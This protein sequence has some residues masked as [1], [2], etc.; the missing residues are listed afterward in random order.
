NA[1]EMSRL[2][3][4]TVPSMEVDRPE[5]LMIGMD[6]RTLFMSN[7]VLLEKPFGARKIT[8][9]NPVWIHSKVS[10]KPFY[11]ILHRIDVGIVIDLE[12]ARIEDP[13]LSIA[14]AVQSH[15]LAVRAVSHFQFLPGGDVK[16]FCDTVVESVR[17]IWPP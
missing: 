9:L 5:L 2:N 13:A 17:Q 15:K 8:L 10:G 3:P 6:V 12:P 14:G 16:I 4:H 1:R 11:A 7:S